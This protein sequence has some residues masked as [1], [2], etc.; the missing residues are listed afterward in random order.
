VRV[1]LLA[2][3]A[4]PDAEGLRLLTPGRLEAGLAKFA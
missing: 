2:E 1:L 3:T 4:P